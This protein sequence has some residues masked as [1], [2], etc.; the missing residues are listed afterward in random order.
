MLLGVSE[1]LNP[2]LWTVGIFFHP[3]TSPLF[4][5]SHKPTWGKI[6]SVFLILKSAPTCGDPT[7]VKIP[8]MKD[9]SA[10]QKYTPIQQVDGEMFSTC[11]ASCTPLLLFKIS[12]S[13]A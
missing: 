5:F 12:A 4:F 11:A 2:L 13:A 7:S 1:F 10:H 9:Q 3:R 6:Y 8:L